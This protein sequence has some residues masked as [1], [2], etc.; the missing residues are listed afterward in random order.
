M[1]DTKS[2]ILLSINDLS[3]QNSAGIPLVT[4]IQ[5]EI[6]KGRIT[7]L[8]GP[9]GCGKSVTAM[10]ILGQLSPQLKRT[11]GKID[12]VGQSQQPHISAIFQEPL[13][14]LNPVMNCGNQLMENIAART[15]SISQADKRKLAENYLEQ[16][17]LY[18][19][20]ETMSKY[21]HQLSGG[22][23]QRLMIAMALASKPDL[24][25]AD[26]PTTSLDPI[27]Q[28]EILD[29]L[30]SACKSS[31]LTLLL[32]THDA[33][34]L[35]QYCDQVI[36]MVDGRIVKK[37]LDAAFWKTETGVVKQ[38]E[39]EYLPKGDQKEIH[40]NTILTVD[41]LSVNYGK[42]GWLFRL[43]QISPLRPAL[44]NLTFSLAEGQI[45]AVIGK[46]GSGKSSLARSLTLP[47]GQVTGHIRFQGKD[48][49]IKE[50]QVVHP[51]CQMIW[52]DPQSSLNPRMQIGT[53]LREVAQ[54][55][56]WSQAKVDVE[57]ANAVKALKLDAE[58]LEKYANQISGG[59]KQ[60]VAIARA[61]LAQPLVLIC[62][63][64]TA[65][66]DGATEKL[67]IDLLLKLRRE[68]GLGIIFITHQL[69]LVDALAS[70]VLVLDEGRCVDFGSLE[71]AK[72]TFRSAAYLGFSRV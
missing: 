25:I 26:E 55:Q 10:A 70:H 6:P 65:S 72:N 68:K 41:A 56:G 39:T 69:H 8:C 54:K 3:I 19:I 23:R 4:D 40:Q 49:V 12:W 28:R 36:E 63:E 21:P 15:L 67:I 5:F 52:Q 46:S 61:L 11:S 24:L 14:A 37:E 48:C 38:G 58:I 22:Q 31:G 60:R 7:G 33:R 64:I 62:D 17:S 57:I 20:A 50:D 29:L 9:S 51:R 1:S 66:V 47:R 53:L 71:E 13:A 59:Q 27:V 16:V 35:N 32:I 42:S 30:I 45:L 43:R 2:H 44:Q 34:I 18:P